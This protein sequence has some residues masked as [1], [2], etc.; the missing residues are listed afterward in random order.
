MDKQFQPV[1]NV[2]ELSYKGKPGKKDIKIFVSHRIDLDSETIPN[3][4]YVN[5]RCGA[6][7]DDRKGMMLFGDDTGDNISE[8][9]NRFCELTVQYWA[10][11]NIDA[12]YYGLCHYRRYLSFLD[13]NIETN[14]AQG[15]VV[16]EALVRETAKKY[17]LLDQGKMRALIEKSDVITSNLYDFSRIPYFPRPKNEMELWNNSPDL[18]IFHEDLL[19]MKDLVREKFPQY[20]TTLER[21]LEADTHRGFNCYIMKKEYFLQMCDFQFSVL[22]EMEKRIELDE[23]GGR[24]ER[25]LGYLGEILYGTYIEWMKEQGKCVV[26]KQ[27]VLF[28]DTHKVENTRKRQYYDG[29]KRFLRCILPGYRVAL[30]LEEKYQSQLALTHQMQ[31]QMQGLSNAITGLNGIARASF[32]L[33]RLTFWNSNPQHVEGLAEVRKMFWE[34]Y[35]PANGE[36]RQ[37]QMGNRMLLRKLKAYSDAA[38]I[39]F[40]MHGGSLVGSLRHKGFIPWDDD[41]DVGIMRDDLQKLQVFLEDTVFEIAEYY[42][43]GLGCR[44]YRFKLRDIGDEF[45]VDLFP[46]D[47]HTSETESLKDEWIKM[48]NFK[49]GLVR[50]FREIVARYGVYENNIRLEQ[51]PELKEEVDRLINTYIRRFRAKT[52]SD[53]IAWGI[54]NNFENK[55]RFAWHNGRIFLERELFPLKTA[56]FEGEIYYIP[57]DYEKYVFAEYGIDYLEMPGDVNHTKHVP[58]LFRGKNISELCKEMEE[59]IASS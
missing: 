15:F 58:E 31:R 39:K 48:R 2:R 50:I 59:R 28:K 47:Y 14:Q 10:W 51:Y 57:A 16:E 1:P 8:K 37:I 49:G 45:F 33:N 25:S 53:Y 18:L 12:D 13:D 22:F 41:V 55:T 20:Y 9:R 46:Y 11:K 36:L 30:R 34:T 52:P 24:A 27:I 5:V 7:Y 54:D 38:G 43:S 3:P 44:A 26:E 19:K 23:Y 42:Y 32:Q 29:F 35:P 6:V 17:A 21:I 40:W 56:E 4:L